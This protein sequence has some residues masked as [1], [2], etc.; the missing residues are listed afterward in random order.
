MQATFN[1]TGRKKIP[2]HDVEIALHG[3]GEGRS[4]EIRRLSL[5]GLP[6]SAAIYV[7]AHYRSGWK[8][9]NFGTVGNLQPPLD[10]RLADFTGL[11]IINF[12]VKVVDEKEEV[13][14]LLAQADGIRVSSSSNDHYSKDD[15]KEPLLPIQ[16]CSDM[17]QEIC[18]VNWENSGPILEVNEKI[19]EAKGF[20]NHS[21][22]FRS[23][24]LPSVFREILLRILMTEANPEHGSWEDKWLLFAKRYNG[25]PPP[26]VKDVTDHSLATDWVDDTITTFCHK[27]K[28]LA[29]LVETIAGGN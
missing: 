14:H 29:K 25:G 7:E 24:V 18:R 20:T 10:T 21:P 28:M 22:F 12:R 26:G 8:R 6:E 19:P 17:G 4:F 27:T 15:N 5:E 9:F 3:E 23:L 16:Y 11:D 2:R 1:F 13:G